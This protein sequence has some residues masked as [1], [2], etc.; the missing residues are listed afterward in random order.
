MMAS[1]L[2]YGGHKVGNLL[3]SSGLVTE[4]VLEGGN[5]AYRFRRDKITTSG[6]EKRTAVILKSD[7]RFRF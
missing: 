2:Q 4:S 1:I 3:P 7:F 5:L 6:F